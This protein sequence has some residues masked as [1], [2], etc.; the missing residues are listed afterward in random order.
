MTPILTSSRQAIPDWLE[1][2]PISRR[3]LCLPEATVRA[4]MELEIPA[5]AGTSH[6]QFSIIVL[7]WNKLPFTK[8]LLNSLF[9][10]T[11]SPPLEVIVV[12]NG[13]T[14]ET[15]E[16]LRALT[17]HNPNVRAIFNNSN[18]GFAAANNQGLAICRGEKIVLLNNDTIVPPGW[19]EAF[20]S[21]LDVPHIGLVGPVTNRIG[22]EAEIKTSYRTYGE[23]IIESRERARAFEG[24]RF[25]IARPAMFCLG[26]TRDTFKKIGLLD[27]QFGVG[28]F[29][30][31]DYAHR[32]RLAGLNVVC[33]E[34]VLIH[35]FSETSFGD[36]FADGRHRELFDA[37][38]RRFERKWNIASSIRACPNEC[39]PDISNVMPNTRNEHSA[40]NSATVAHQPAASSQQPECCDVAQS[41]DVRSLLAAVERR[42]ETRMEDLQAR[43]YDLEALIWR[44][45]SGGADETGNGY[46][47]VIRNVREAIR[48]HIPRDGTI[49]VISKGDNHLLD[50]YGRKACHFPCDEHRAYIGYYPANSTAATA[51]LEW[52]RS[53]GCDY[54]CIPET[55]R[56]WL[57]SYASFAAHLQS[58]YALIL[59]DS[60]AGL[61]YSLKP[62]DRKV[63]CDDDGSETL[64]TTAARL[65][66]AFGRE[67]AIL[68]WTST[69][70]TENGSRLAI[71]KLRSGNPKNDD[72]LPYVDRSIDIIA[73][74]DQSN[75]ARSAEA[76]RVA[77]SAVV[78]IRAGQSRGAAVVRW[79]S[80]PPS[81]AAAGVSIVI[82]VH[83]AVEHTS[84]C[85]AAVRATL[86][87]RKDIELIVV[88]DASTDDTARTLTEMSAR[89]PR[90][91]VIRSQE[92][93]GF[94]A[95]AN[96]GAAAASNEILVF[97]NNDTI[98]LPGWLDALVATFKQYPQCGAAGGKL[99]FPD[100]RLQEAGG[101]VFRDGSA[102]H[103]GRNDAD[104][105]K[106]LFDYVRPVDYCSGA[107]L[108][109]K[110]NVFRE[111][112][113]FDSAFAPGYYE[114][115]DYCFRMRARGLTVLYQPRCAVVHLEG[116][117]A[118]T[119][120]AHGM[121]RF[122]V[123]NQEKFTKRWQDALQKQIERPAH[124]ND[125]TWHKI[126]N[127][128][129]EGAH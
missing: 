5:G 60:D 83:N 44:Q 94:V 120:L 128:A 115:T 15:C 61:I 122:Q 38:R 118:G 20:D 3:P 93:Q 100:G 17:R 101:V 12:D 97:L 29:E 52:L 95:S 2:T 81:K 78:V 46:G 49:A 41:R 106:S 53:R 45:A 13:S 10:N 71:F 22:N 40:V 55:A 6:P 1:L 85:L 48:R 119:D 42:F 72:M 73:V 103:F 96:L 86:G 34:D 87:T 102:A 111:L 79:I 23:Y 108:A 59:D 75:A 63:S 123:V 50:A 21:H 4:A 56:W 8:L 112:G 67:P 76:G 66:A 124:F 121:K 116:A 58:R 98:P 84:N 7:T 65:R 105:D 104:C 33:A 62:S 88:D 80:E 99:L 57:K 39:S 126:A 51:N 37:N 19:L 43:I 30:D 109:T 110:R 114:D 36:L 125:A 32:A 70:L 28:L 129:W 77:S 89:E 127:A 82:P 69:D 113:G 24:R 74:D 107:L 18:R 35:H 91:K 54:L 92:N 14:D 68:D 11:K 117:S 9:A 31:D 47:D 90:L 26:F 16:F 64:E 25:T 27:E